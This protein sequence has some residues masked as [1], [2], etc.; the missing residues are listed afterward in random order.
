[1]SIIHMFM[2]AKIIS[3]LFDKQEISD[4]LIE[5]TKIFF[6]GKNKMLRL[7]QLLPRDPRY[8]RRNDEFL[9]AKRC[10]LHGICTVELLH[11][12]RLQCALH[13]HSRPG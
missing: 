13:L 10:R 5:F 2:Y 12:H 6:S 8:F 11:Q 7:H 1:M 3:K 4:V 9:V